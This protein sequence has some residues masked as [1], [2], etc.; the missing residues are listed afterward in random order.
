MKF[1]VNLLYRHIGRKYPKFD[2]RYLAPPP[3][4]GD[5]DFG[6]VGQGLHRYELDFLE[7]AEY[8]K[9]MLESLENDKE[10]LASMWF[11]RIR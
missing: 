11:D 4:Y 7:A 5:L 10:L 8:T 6:N 1:T 9:D 2:K 3:A